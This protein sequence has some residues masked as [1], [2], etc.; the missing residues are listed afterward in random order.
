MEHSSHSHPLPHGQHTFVQGP[1]PTPS[2]PSPR[3]EHVDNIG[4]QARKLQ[5]RNARFNAAPL[6]VRRISPLF[7]LS[8]SSESQYILRVKETSPKGSQNIVPDQSSQQDTS[9]NILQEIQNSARR[10]RASP[11][12]G[13]TTIFESEPPMDENNPGVLGTS[14]YIDK[15]NEC[16]PA[17]NRTPLTTM[18][19]REGTLNQRMP[20]PLSSPSA[21]QSKRRNSIFVDHDR[22]NVGQARYIEHLESQ[23]ASALAKID[24]LNSPKTAKMRTAKL[25]SLNVENRNLRAENASWAKKAEDMVEEQRRIHSAAEAETN[26]QL[27]SLKEDM[28]S[29]GSRIAELE[30]EIESMGVKMK[31]AEGLVEAN[32]RLEKRIDLLSTLVVKSPTKIT[33]RSTLT[34]PRKSDSSARVPRPASML[35]GAPS[36]P[37][38]LR[39]SV[40]SISESAF[41]DTRSRSTSSIVETPEGD[42]SEQVHNAQLQI[43]AEEEACRSAYGNPDTAE[44]AIADNT[45]RDSASF[46]SAP[47]SS[48]RPASFI[49]TSSTGAPPWGMPP[50]PYSEVRASGRQRRMRRFP[51]GSSSLKPLILPSTSTVTSFPASAPIFPSIDAI[52]N[53]DIPDSR[54]DPISAAFFTHLVENQLDDTPTAQPRHRNAAWVQEQTLKALVGKKDSSETGVNTNGRPSSS[55]FQ[56]RPASVI[57]SIATSPRERQRPQSLQTELERAEH[58]ATPHDFLGTHS[59]E[60]VNAY[61]IHASG[62]ERDAD[63]CSAVKSPPSRPGDVPRRHRRGET[64]PRAGRGVKDRLVPMSNFKARPVEAESSCNQADGLL[65]RFTHVITQTRQD[66]VTLARRIVHNA[67][68]LGSSSLGGIAWWLVGPLHHH[69]HKSGRRW[70]SEGHPERASENQGGQPLYPHFTGR[71]SRGAQQQQRDY[72]ST[73]TSSSGRYARPHPLPAIVPPSTSSLR[74]EPHL[75]PCDQCEEP[76]SRRTIRMWFHFCLTVVLAVG[77]AV[78]HG[79]GALIAEPTVNEGEIMSAQVLDVSDEEEEEEGEDEDR[80]SDNEREVDGR[81][82]REGNLMCTDTPFVPSHPY[83]RH[84]NF[85]VPSHVDPE[86]TVRLKPPSAARRQSRRDIGVASSGTRRAGSDLDSGY[87]SIAFTEPFGMTEFEAASPR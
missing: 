20:T 45:S 76:S 49:S 22:E 86:A 24:S 5:I 23:L 16:S 61:H 77:M 68:N 73:W 80:N 55:R 71:P 72:G 30:W 15:S 36:S 66:P 33:T 10:K 13:V 83:P 70:D 41:W 17:V 35:V 31:E 81:G 56:E 82:G 79:P 40:T 26:A 37:P 48:S 39:H 52:T 28:D 3:G 32:A 21:K 53:E 69:S 50:Q 87:G 12:P 7:G 38:L 51:S 67:W 54:M 64:T 60:P 2:C 58:G 65:Q 11:K 9:L 57:G 1:T 19:L 85:S 74:D 84:Q 34:S 42:E 4:A 14:W 62:Q 8:H 46:R 29:K 27:E 78:R 43:E 59:R 47:S 63:F 75:F 18:G 44:S 25:R 6:S